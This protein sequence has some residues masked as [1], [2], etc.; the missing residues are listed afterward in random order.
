MEFG[1]G[2]RWMSQIVICWVGYLHTC[3]GSDNCLTVICDPEPDH[4]LDVEHPS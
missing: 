2:H 3:G 4:R 1:N